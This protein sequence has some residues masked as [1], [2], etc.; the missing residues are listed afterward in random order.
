MKKK[1][2]IPTYTNQHSVHKYLIQM[3]QHLEILKFSSTGIRYHPMI[4]R[5]YLSS[6][7]IASA[8]YY[9]ILVNEKLGSSFLIPPS[10]YRLRKYNYYIKPER[11]FNQNIMCELQN[12][13][14]KN[15]DKEKCLVLLMDEMKIKENLVWDKHNGELIGYL[16][17]GESDLN[18]ATLLKVTTVAPHVF[19]FLIRSILNLLKFS[20]ANFP[21]DGISGL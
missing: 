19:V 8:A 7:A 15:S 14:K 12:K 18:Y 3:L 13:V 11:G 6:V 16:D 17:L 1:L 5:C 4:I 20:L 21:A 2:N 9:E 10:H